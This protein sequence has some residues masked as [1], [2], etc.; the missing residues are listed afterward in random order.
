M[1]ALSDFERTFGA[2]TR[3]AA[4]ARCVVSTGRDIARNDETLVIQIEQVG[5]KRP[6]AGVA[7]AP[8]AVHD[9]SHTIH[10]VIP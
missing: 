4:R 9:D 3:G 8:L 7:L 10:G 6:A 5:R 1:P 2:G